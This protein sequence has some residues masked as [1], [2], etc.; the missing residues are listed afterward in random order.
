MPPV[1]P[2]IC[3]GR[4]E[5]NFLALGHGQNILPN[6]RSPRSDMPS[7]QRQRSSLDEADSLTGRLSLDK[8]GVIR[9]S[10]GDIVVRSESQKYPVKNIPVDAIDASGRSARYDEAKKM[11]AEGK[12]V[13]LRGEFQRL[14]LRGSEAIQAQLTLFFRISK[15]CQRKQVAEKVNRP[16]RVVEPSAFPGFL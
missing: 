10:S 16:N 7:W 1:S 13:T 12:T 15:C 8:D 5:R 3:S 4:Y 11:A 6:S 14:S 2:G 9:L